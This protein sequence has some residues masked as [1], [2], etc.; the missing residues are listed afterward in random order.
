[1]ASNDNIPSF[2]DHVRNHCFTVEQ[3]AAYIP[4]LDGINPKPTTLESYDGIMSQFKEKLDSGRLPSKIFVIRPVLN[5]EYNE[6]D[7]HVVGFVVNPDGR[8]VHPEGIV[9][10]GKWTITPTIN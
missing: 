9:G 3:L 4:T 8:V 6:Y 7:K 5:E 2:F 10:Y 1:M